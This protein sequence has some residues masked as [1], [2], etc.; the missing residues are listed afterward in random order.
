MGIARGTQEIKYAA[1]ITPCPSCGAREH[2][3]LKLRGSGNR[4][5]MVGTCPTCRQPLT[6]SYDTVGDPLDAPM[7]S[8][9]LGTGP[10]TIL[11]ADQL[12]A[13]LA[14]VTPLVPRDPKSLAPDAWRA[15]WALL[16]R[17]VVTANELRK[18]S[19]SSEVTRK[20]EELRALEGK[21]KADGARSH[22]EEFPHGHKGAL[23]KKSLTAHLSWL[24]N[25]RRGDGRLDLAS[26]D[27]TGSAIG[28]ENLTGARFAGV[29]L[30]RAALRHATLDQIEL[31]DVDASA[32]SFESAS[33][34]ATKIQG[35]TYTQAIFTYADLDNVTIDGA[36]LAGASFHN[37]FW[38]GGAVTKTNLAGTR[39]GNAKLDNVVFKDCDF[40]GSSFAAPEELPEPLTR[41]VRFESCDLRD[42]DWAGRDLTGATFVGCKL[43]GAHGAPKATARVTVENCDVSQSAFLAQLR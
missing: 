27:L 12:R 38:N 8:D 17:A 4:W 7:H 18:L 13:E 36:N 25:H 33:M 1:S 16:D 24:Q 19:P 21:Y 37:T 22:Q 14:R 20:L 23:D 9:E 2:G 39:F 31:L 11:T 34:R 3:D 41:S 10:S 15:G 35:G 40:R 26:T 32:A 42:T 30:V 5:S 6:F 43:S 28:A 29:K